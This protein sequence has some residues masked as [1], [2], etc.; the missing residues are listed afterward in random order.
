MKISGCFRWNDRNAFYDQTNNPTEHVL[1]CLLP[2]G[3]S[4]LETCGPTAGLNCLASIGHKVEILA[5]GGFPLQP[6][7]AL[8]DWF[9]D[10]RNFSR[11][12][13]NWY[14]L[15]PEQLPGN[16]VVEWYP[17]AIMEVFGQ[18]CVL[19]ERLIDQRAIEELRM[20]H[21]LQVCLR[22]P[23]HF[24][25]LVGFDEETHDFILKDSWGARWPDGDGFCRRMSQ[26]EYVANV[27][28]KG[29]IY[30]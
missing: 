9:N 6:E 24:I 4:A 12:K 14:G 2:Q 13:A 18:R 3:I 26:Q 28:P 23:H 10:P 27:K 16:E 15:D 22:N 25:A 5:P 19:E 7:E 21:A 11:M 20:G 29:L 1:K 8:S 30:Y 17:M